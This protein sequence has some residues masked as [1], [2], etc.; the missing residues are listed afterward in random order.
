MTPMGYPMVFIPPQQR[1]R[2]PVDNGRPP[3]RVLV[4]MNLLASFTEKMRPQIAVNDVGFE[5]IDGQNLTAEEEECHAV[6]ADLITSWLQ[7][8]LP[9]APEEKLAERRKRKRRKTSGVKGTCTS[10][11]GNGYMATGSLGQGRQRCSLCGG[12]GFV[13][14]VRFED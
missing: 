13:M 5:Q 14:F 2:R 8:K 12:K 10:C 6:A 3:V 1:E 9:Q 4:A 7:G 11:G